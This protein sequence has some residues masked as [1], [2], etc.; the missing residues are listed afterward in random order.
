MSTLKSIPELYQSLKRDTTV[1]K[2]C[3]VEDTHGGYYMFDK[4]EACHIIST[5]I[6]K[7]WDNFNKFSEENKQTLL[8]YHE[9]CFKKPVPKDQSLVETA[10]YV[11]YYLADHAV[12]RTERTPVTSS[13]RVSTILARQ[14]FVGAVTEGVGDLK[15]P[16]ALKCLDLFRRALKEHGEDTGEANRVIRHITEDHLKKFVTDNGGELKTR[17]DPWRIFQYYRP[18]LIAA[19]LIKTK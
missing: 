2:H 19:K 4:P 3:I 10:V 8:T 1:L 11:W 9:N 14:Y 13:G 6:H 16:Q 7:K 12:D 17:Q 18:N 15:T 5:A